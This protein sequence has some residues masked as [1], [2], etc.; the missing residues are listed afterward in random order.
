MAWVALALHAR[1]KSRVHAGQSAS[2]DITTFTLTEL[3]AR[4]GKRT[5]SPIDVTN[6]Y[7][8][9]IALLNPE[10]NAFVTIT[11]ERARAD[12]WRASRTLPPAPATSRVPMPALLGAPIAHK[13]L[14]ETSGIRTTAGSRLYES[15]IPKRDAF[16]VS[17]LARAGAVLLGKTNTH[18]LGGGVTTINPFYGTTR[19][20]VDRARIPGG[21]SGGSAAAV[22]A[23]LCVA[24]TGSDTGGSVR[25]PAALCGCVGFKPT[26]GRI[27][28]AGLLGSSPMF[29]HVGFLTRTVEDAELMFAAAVDK[30]DQPP[31]KLRRSAETSAKAEGLSNPRGDPPLGLSGIHIGVVRPF[32]FDGLQPDV[33]RAMEIAIQRFGS[34]GAGVEEV[35][36]PIDGSTM[37]RVFDPIVVS[38]I[39]SSLGDAWW[40]R[41]DAFSKGFAGFFETPPPAAATV[42]ASR[43]ALS[44]FRA[45]VD[46]L[47]DRV[48]ILL[49][50]TVPIT[51]PPVE[52]RIDGG[53]ILR[54]TWAFNA[55]GTPAISI[56]CGVDAAGL[57][58]GLQLAARRQ[59]DQ[60]LL[61]VGGAFEH[62]I[63]R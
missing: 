38:E 48:Q 29:D 42:A 50:P 4:T 41:P 49:T 44:D 22:A 14:L 8:E 58:I 2:D 31:L 34:I 36:L 33:A 37:S 40:R 45:A 12:A 39:W 5:L 51:A 53:L 32:F 19:N 1:T 9:R 59:H 3:V 21:S 30:P 55:A 13:D 23:R 57:P 47:F 10:L 20:P 25:I 60:L 61:K 6:A 62:E 11:A 54:N 35:A 28:T 43:R 7:L 15:H 16:V 18:E 17:Q 27:S 26:F 52:G 24:A 56:P 63:T 46:R